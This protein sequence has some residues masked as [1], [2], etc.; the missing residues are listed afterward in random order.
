MTDQPLTVVLGYIRRVAA[1]T[2]PSEADRDLLERFLA[3][4][5]EA[6]FVTLVERH[7]P[8]VL[9][10]C[11]RVL[12]HVHDAEDA[13]QATFLVLARKAAS[14]RAKES[15]A[16][17]LH[18]VAH[19]IATNLKRD[20]ARR[21]AWEERLARKART[22]LPPGPTWREVRAALDD[23]LARL[24]ERYRGP[25][26]LCYLEGRTRDEAARQLGWSLGTLRGRLERGRELLRARLVRR[27]LTLSAALGAGA[28]LA[29]SAG[30]ALPAAF[31][32]TVTQAARQFLAGQGAGVARAATLATRALAEAYPARARLAAVL[33]ALLLVAGLGAA[34]ASGGNG[35]GK[36]PASGGK[37]PAAAPQKDTGAKAEKEAMEQLAGTWLAVAVESDGR[38]AA[39]EE[40]KDIRYIFKAD[41]TWEMHQ[42]A[43][44]LASGTYRLDVA[45]KPRTIDYQIVES[46]A[47][48]DRGK[49][50]RGIYELD[51]DM[52]R[53]CRT[54]P[55]KDG[56]PEAFSADAGSKH[57][58]STFKRAAPQA[59]PALRLT[60]VGPEGPIILDPQLPGEI[61]L[62]LWLENTSKKPIVICLPVDGSLAR[63]RDPQYVFRL[64]DGA[65][66]ELLMND[67]GEGNLNALTARDFVELQPGER[68]EVLGPAEVFGTVLTYSFT[69]LKPGD[70]ELTATYVLRGK[71]PP[72]SKA[73]G[74]LNDEAAVLWKAAHR[75]EVT[76]NKVTVRFAAAPSTEHLLAVLEGKEKW[77]SAA[78]AILIL[79]GRRDLRGLAPTF[80]ALQDAKA[81]VRWAAAFAL[82]HYAAAYSV[83][84]LQDKDIIPPKLFDALKQAA[85]DPELRVREAAA[86]SLRF[87]EEYLAAARKEKGK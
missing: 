17:W 65:G 66:K 81:E 11:R 32:A 18:G 27:G 28:L 5:D 71:N 67:G 61:S 20:L 42:G 10:T 80:K 50:S 9:G 29:E 30:A 53:V 83:G 7:G 84:Q 82:R 79:G 87:A 64:V 16:G 58:L 3:G 77:P 41:G 47:A 56:R 31:V 72:G 21:Q 33:L 19:H 37:V 38:Q 52:L 86:T 54:W 48:Q 73:P 55:E 57:I 4:R 59:A 39:E 70:Y 74:A 1:Q 60:L 12:R 8:M 13:C 34:L 36:V 35:A 46:V 25:L 24:P 78:E 69:G 76:S 43:A 75:C 22:P 15:L 68:M 49:T 6:A 63:S 23:E 14:I 51:G 44:V 45:K 26:V 40:I 85:A 62:R 2:A